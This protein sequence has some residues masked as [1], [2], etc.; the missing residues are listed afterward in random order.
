MNVSNNKKKRLSS[1]SDIGLAFDKPTKRQKISS[2]SLFINGNGR[3]RWQQQQQQQTQQENSK[4]ILSSQ[5]NNNNINKYILTPKYKN[6]IYFKKE[7]QERKKRLEQFLAINKLASANDKSESLRKQ[8]VFE[9][10]QNKQRKDEQL[11]AELKEWQRKSDASKDKIQKDLA[12][13]LKKKALEKL[14]RAKKNNNDN[15]DPLDIFMSHLQTKN[16]KKKNKN[17]KKEERI[18]ND[19]S[20][21][22]EGDL[23]IENE[24]H[25][26]TESILN[27]N[28][29]NNNNNNKKEIKLIDH[30]KINYSSI[31]KNLYVESPE[32]SLISWSDIELIRKNLLNNCKIT[33]SSKE[34]DI[35]PILK[36]TQCGLS[37]NILSI[38]N[39]YKY[40][41]PFAVQ[42]QCIP[43]IMSGRD[44]ICIASTGSGKTLCYILPL[45]RHI[46]INYGNNNYNNNNNNHFVK[47]IIL[48]PTRELVQQIYIE[49]KKF[50]INYSWIR[51]VAIYG[52]VSI[53]EQ[54]NNLR[55]GCDIIIA[56][57][58]RLI[59]LLCTNCGRLLDIKYISYFVLDEADRL[60]DLGFESQITSILQNV[61]PD[62]QLLMFSATFP[63]KIEK[64]AIKYFLNN[65]KKKN[66]NL[67]Q[68]TIGN[69][70]CG[71]CENVAQF[72]YIVDN[73]KEKFKSLLRLLGEWY[74]K[75]NILIFVDT[76]NNVDLLFS[77][78]CDSGYFSLILH[79]GI[80]QHDRCNTIIDFKNKEKTILICTSI[81]SRGLDVNDLKIV[82]NY[83]P[84]HHYE[85]YI[86]RIGRTGRGNN[87]GVS[88]TFIN[89]NNLSFELK[90]I[91]HIIK[92][93][94]KSSNKNNKLKENIT[95]ELLLLQQEYYKKVNNGNEIIHRNCGYNGKGYKYDKFESNLKKKN[96]QRQKYVYGEKEE[97]QIWNLNKND[98]VQQIKNHHD[99]NHHNKDKKNNISK[100]TKTTTTTTT[101]TNT[102]I[103]NPLKRNLE[104]LKKALLAA[105]KKKEQIIKKQKKNKKLKIN[106]STSKEIIKKTMERTIEK[107]KKKHEKE[108]RDRVESIAK[109]ITKEIEMPS[110]SSSSSSSSST[111]SQANNN[112]NNNNNNDNNNNNNRLLIYKLDINDYA[113][114]VRK[115]ITYKATL[116][117]LRENYNV[118][119]TQKGQYIM[120]NNKSHKNNNIESLYLEIRGRN[121]SDIH[122][123]IKELKQILYQESSKTNYSHNKYNK[124]SVV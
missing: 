119:I 115:A 100:T 108:T 56:T 49:C 109:M 9:A 46:L 47:S 103:D 69:Q 79:G 11:K 120:N 55:R 61:R 102:T 20:K 63:K 111:T 26:S 38:L 33:V 23:L 8:T 5:V 36:W 16:T 64:V 105:K 114:N 112:N 24:Y 121:E 73:E 31:R 39:K 25:L 118:R 68:L 2:N 59:E 82:I 53:T 113:L 14:K 32:I 41:K 81:A 43:I 77:K 123:A 12:Q 57:P 89:R 78:L 6:N 58:G 3:S 101:T 122:G 124:Y 54:I 90:C 91:P 92:A 86:H 40:N 96:I 84:P 35:K 117:P 62:K 67:I 7:A 30:S 45:I 37:N 75:G 34:F 66:N 87:R 95:N 15:I 94:K 80:D 107:E 50:L 10:T 22:D 60:F 71:P 17:N 27:N 13:R 97:L 19:E 116:N 104:T 70:I 28:N 98:D 93:M 4:N 18:Y 65:N 72:V 48:C 44:L 76:R 110:L 106:S 51:C 52:G 83:Y 1:T 42:S 74:G 85:D 21:F 29:N 99:D 88:Y